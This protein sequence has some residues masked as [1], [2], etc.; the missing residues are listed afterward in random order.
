MT[1]EVDKDDETAVTYEGL[2]IY[3]ELLIRDEKFVH[4][5]QVGLSSKLDLTWLQNRHRVA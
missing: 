3:L 5:E 2:H 1:L 4:R